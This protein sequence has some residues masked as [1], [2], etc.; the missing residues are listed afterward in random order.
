MSL[1]RRRLTP[2]DLEIL[3]ML[4]RSP[5]TCGQLL[6]VSV[7]FADGAF[8]SLRSV[9][10]RLCKLRAVGWVRSW[11]YATTARGAAPEYFRLSPLGYELLHGAGAV[12]A[13]R[14]QF[15]EVGLAHQ[16]HTRALADVLVRLHAAA[17]ARGVTLGR[18]FAEN[19]L[20]LAVDGESLY[21]D[22]AFELAL[23]DGRQ[24]NYLVELDCGS[25]RVRSTRDADSWQRKIRLYDRLQDENHPHRFRVLIVHTRGGE[26]LDHILRTAAA[27]LRNPQRSLFLGV[28]LAAFLQVADPLA[29][30]LFRDH[31]GRRLSLLGEPVRLPKRR[32]VVNVNRVNAPALAL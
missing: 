25:E 22:C 20:R 7:T 29:A 9:Q 24:L 3:A 1:P 30:R 26:R 28:E 12:P 2:R 10:D 21:P 23:P 14:R 11:R 8:T 15:M 5:L 13:S 4:D 17:Q 31:Q 6:T 16:R 32:M 27:L 18:F 19:A